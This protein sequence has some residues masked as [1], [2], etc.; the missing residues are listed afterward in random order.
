M[1]IENK[2]RIKCNECNV[3]L[4]IIFMLVIITFSGGVS[5]ADWPVFLGDNSR[6]SNSRQWFYDPLPEKIWAYDMGNPAAASPVIAEGIVITAD[7][8]GNVYAFDLSS[9]D[10]KGKQ[11]LGYEI[12]ST[13]VLDMEGGSGFVFTLSG[14]L[15]ELD[16]GGGTV[17]NIYD[18]GAGSPSSPLVLEEDI[19]VGRGWPENDLVRICRETKSIKNVF[20]VGQ[21]VWSSPIY[22]G[23][24]IYVAANDGNVYELDRELN[25]L[26]VF[27]TETGIFRTSSLSASGGVLYFAPG[28][29]VRG[30]Y[31][32]NTSGFTSSKSVPLNTGGEGVYTSSVAL[33]EDGNLYVVISSTVQVLYSLDSK[34]LELS[35]SRKLAESQDKSFQPTPVYTDGIVYTGT[36]EGYFKG[37]YTCDDPLKGI[38]AG[39]KA[40]EIEV[41]SA[42]MVVSPAVSDGYLALVTDSGKVAVY[43]AANAASITSPRRGDV[44]MGEGNIISGSARADGFEK[45]ELWYASGTEWKII[46]SSGSQVNS[47]TLAQWDVSGL[48]DGY[49]E[50]R[51]RVITGNITGEAFGSVLVDNPPLP[52][53]QVTAEAVDASGIMISWE[54]SPDDGGGNDDVEGYRIYRARGSTG[55]FDFS[56]PA[57]EAGLGAESF[58]DGDLEALTTYYYTV[59]S[60]DSRSESEDA[61]PVSAYIDESFIVV[62]DPPRPPSALRAEPKDGPLVELSWSLSPDDGSG[63]GSVSG[64]NLYRVEGS[65]GDFPDSALLAKLS[66]GTAAYTDSSAASFTTYYYLIKSFNEYGESEGAGPAAAYIDE[67]LVWFDIPAEKGGTAEIPCGTSVYFPPGSVR[68]GSRVKI[69]PLHRDEVPDAGAAGNWVPYP[70]A[71]RFT[72]EPDQRF[73]LPASITLVP[74][75]GGYSASSFE[76]MRAYWYD[77]QDDIYRMVDTSEPD[78]SA[79]TVKA[80]VERFALFRAGRYIPS[81]KIISEDNLYTYPNP[82][83]G[84]EAVIRFLLGSQARVNIRIFNVAGEPVAELSESYTDSDAGRWQEIRWDISSVASGVYIYRVRASGETGSDEVIKKTAVIK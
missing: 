11:S 46:I 29:S 9:G 3:S 64:Y 33:G 84:D 16:T 4:G 6:T 53:S 67:S 19:Y 42:S 1:R 65:T 36:E 50:L 82:A 57:G 77:P 56:A 43:K 34:T 60:F 41:S 2:N 26:R 18:L 72:V 8:A 44:F 49:Y 30:V 78:T 66:T 69:E 76:F 23:G 21:P 73:R 17:K 83:F 24:L 68:E 25:K 70:S 58:Y 59:R 80:D 47:E 32:L 45:Y 20:H 75:E 81:G 35:W 10:E 63:D 28:D 5:R 51:L 79:N 61:G 52:P 22:H 38:E 27:E 13:P 55:S 48:K 7:R 74:P 14:K 39:D 12:I 40:V 62:T 37:F 71:W 54:K 31:S 15:F